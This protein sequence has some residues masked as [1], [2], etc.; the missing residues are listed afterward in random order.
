MKKFKSI[1]ITGLALLIGVSQPMLAQSKKEKKEQKEKEVKEL[2]ESGR[3]TIEVDRALPMSG[4]SVNLT[5][6]YSLELR[7]DS[8]ISH[9]PYFGR[10]YNVPYGGGDGLRFSK[11]TKDRT[12]EFDEKGTADIKFD[13][14]TDEDNYT[15]NVKVFNNG[16]ATIMV[17]PTN[18][19]SISFHG[20]LKEKM[21]NLINEE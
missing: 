6:S 5:S 16:S 3:Y 21:K 20:N 4:S 7:G 8:V 17:Q 15:Y 9:L 10:A 12:I 1:F 14:R 11:P 18:R 13:V 19:Q 2:L